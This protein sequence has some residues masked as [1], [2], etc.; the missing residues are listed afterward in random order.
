MGDSPANL[1]D[2][3]ASMG[4]ERKLRVEENLGAGFVRL[5]VAEAERRQA[6]HDI[7]CAEDAVVELLRN[8]RDAGAQRIFVA[9]SRTGDLRTITV[10][11]DGV[12]IPERMHERVFDA[13]VTSKLDSMH[14]DRW[15][16]HGRGMALFSISEN[17]KSARVVASGEGLGTALQVVF[18]SSELP[19]RADQSTWPTVTFDD[20]GAPFVANGPHNLVRTCCEFALEEH[21]TCDVYVGSAAEMVAT[22]RRRVRPSADGTLPLFAD[23]LLELGVLERVVVAGDARELTEAASSVGLEISERTA[24]RIIAGEVRPTRSV[25]T[26]LV[27]PDRESE[28][29]PIDLARD[30]RTLHVSPEDRAGFANVMEDAFSYLGE[31]YYLTLTASPTVRV[32][33]GKV[34]VTFE[35]AELD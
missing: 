3:V 31:R 4:G 23:D 13:R 28:E 9:T 22:I 12:G 14:M 18:D 25:Y 17:A 34:T 2:F 26:R 1:M 33:R 27:R 29:A 6:K 19:E 35:V 5:R 7:R 20:G 15:G 24:H 30:R 16:V 11:D 32:S 10:L 8:S 21:D